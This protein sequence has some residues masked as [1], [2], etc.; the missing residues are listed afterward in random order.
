MRLIV[1]TLEGYKLDSKGRLSIPTK[2]RERL[3]KEFYMVAVTVRECKCLT[4]YPVDFFENT[5]N[6]MQHGSEN[7]KYDATTSFLKDAEETVLDSQGRFTVNHR[8]KELALLTNDSTVVF[9]GMGKY[10]EI[11]NPAEYDRFNGT[12]DSS[13]G[14]YDLMDKMK[15]NDNEV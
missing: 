1:G 10:L 2:W 12:Y 8:L 11:W 7:Q 15:G 13:E 3:G 6:S 14:I 9:K 4:L 5:Y